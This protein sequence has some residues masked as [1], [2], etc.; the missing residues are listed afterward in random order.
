ML[1]TTS[2]M[3]RM[4]IVMRILM[5]M[6]M[7][8][9]IL[10]MVMTLMMAMMSIATMKKTDLNSDQARLGYEIFGYSLHQSH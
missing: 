6:M 2:A 7:M 9:M 5:T 10:M 8:V 4:L 3:M 1:I